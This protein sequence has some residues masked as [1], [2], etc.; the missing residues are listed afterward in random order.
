[1]LKQKYHRSRSRQTYTPPCLTEAMHEQVTDT[2]SLNGDCKTMMA[3]GKVSSGGGCGG[4][5]DVF[6]LRL[7]SKKKYA[8]FVCLLFL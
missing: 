5:G 4:C 6:I 3:F 2:C 7:D 8:W 1:M